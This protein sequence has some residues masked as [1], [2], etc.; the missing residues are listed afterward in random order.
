MAFPPPC[1]EVVVH[2]ASLAAQIEELLSADNPVDETPVGLRNAR[3]DRRRTME[4]I[5]VLLADPGVV[6]TRRSSSA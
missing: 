4:A 2:L 5:L 3:K 1:D 6:N